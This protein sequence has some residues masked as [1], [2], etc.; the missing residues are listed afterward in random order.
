MSNSQSTPQAASND[1]PKTAAP[2]VATPTPQQ[3]QGD[4]PAPKPPEQQ[5]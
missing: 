5:K 1:A 2:G 3:N 4:K